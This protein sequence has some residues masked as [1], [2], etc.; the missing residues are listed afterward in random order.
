M[1]FDMVSAALTPQ[2]AAV[3][4]MM[5]VLVMAI[6][7]SAR[8]FIRE[9]RREKYARTV[10]SKTA[11]AAEQVNSIIIDV[12]Q[13]AARTSGRETSYVLDTVNWFAI[14]RD[15][16]R[17]GLPSQPLLV[18]LGAGV[19]AYALALFVI[20]VPIFEPH[21]VASVIYP[22]VFYV[23]RRGLLEMRIEGRQNTKLRQLVA[24]IETVQRA[25]AIGAAPDEAV[26][27]A[28]AEVPAPLSEDLAAIGDLTDLGYD[29]IDA[30]NLSAER[31]NMSEFDIFVGALTAQSTSGGSV[32]DVLREV[33]EISRARLDLKKKVATLTAEGR[34][35]ALLLGFLPIG[36]S[37]YLR[38]SQPDYIGVLWQSPIGVAIYLGTFGLAVFG[39]WVA[40]RIAKVRV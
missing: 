4:S 35:N 12:E 30:I 16:R 19:I 18:F 37:M 39:A 28:I 40:I 33:I 9:A 14:A 10:I 6:Y 11:D 24:F 22:A 31:I 34:F 27:E 5:S 29:F 21:W 23:V 7:L 36:L 8:R 20:A 3:A 13:R 38:A 15:L 25:V 17:A 2:Q 26:S 1:I 32:G